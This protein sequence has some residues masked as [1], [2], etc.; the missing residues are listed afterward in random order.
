M[1]AQHKALEEAFHAEMMAKAGTIPCKGRWDEEDEAAESSHEWDDDAT[2][3]VSHAAE[4]SG[5]APKDD[6]PA[7]AREKAEVIAKPEETMRKAGDR[8]VAR[9]VPGSKVI[10]TIELLPPFHYSI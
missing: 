3:A 4:E 1:S 5:I 8:A 7:P 10:C 2:W 9:S 6:E